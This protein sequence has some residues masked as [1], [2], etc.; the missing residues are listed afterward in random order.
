MRHFPFFC[1]RSLAVAFGSM[2]LFSVIGVSVAEAAATDRY[3]IGSKTGSNQFENVINWSTSMGGA[4]GQTVPTSSNN[5]FF[6]NNLSGSTLAG[7]NVWIKSNASVKGIVINSG[8]TGAILLGTGSLVVGT[9]GVRMGSGRLIGGSPANP[10][11]SNAGSFTQTGGIVRIGSGSFTLSGSFVATGANTSFV[12]T[13]S[14]IFDG[15]AQNI[16]AAYRAS[17]KN[18]IIGSTTAA[19][20][21]S[22]ISS[23]STTLQIN[24]GATLDVSTFA[25]YA[26][27]ATFINYGTLTEG[28]GGK[29]KKAATSLL[30]TDSTYLVEDDAF[31]TGDTLYLTI[32]D[33]DENIDGTAL[34]T[35]TVTV[36]LGTGDVETVTLTE[37]AVTSGIFRGSIVTYKQVNTAAIGSNN[38][39][40]ETD[41]TSAM[42][43]AYTD[44]QDGGTNSDT[45]TLTAAAAAAASTSTSGSHSG[46]GGGRS[47]YRSTVASPVKT[48]MAPS[49]V[50]STPAPGL[51]LK[52]RAEVRKQARL[53]LL[54]RAADRAAKRRAARGL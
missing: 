44:E 17:F 8:F 35:L 2:Y 52:E 36:T 29:L 31:T 40:L 34:D 32:T 18:L 51:T 48:V 22:D 42:T 37:S 53:A 27:G 7:K 25:I 26:T 4:G 50:N 54:K 19:T 45:A 33:P 3:W 15:T 1:R 6:M 30:T 23:V 41:A 47:T 38:G 21:L 11:I 13:G 16:N 10:I 43:I 5:V 39:A 14:I 24:T 28:S 20:L 12:S 46:G 9:D 49:K